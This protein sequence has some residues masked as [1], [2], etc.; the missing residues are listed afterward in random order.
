MNW[1]R[2]D[3]NGNLITGFFTDKD[4]T[5]Y[6]LDKDGIMVTGWQLIDGKWYY[7]NPVSD[8]T[9]GSLYRNTTTPDGYRVGP[10]GVWDS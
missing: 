8:G 4:G 5:L 10:D 2:F 1:Y 9:R 3:E 7:F 6:Y